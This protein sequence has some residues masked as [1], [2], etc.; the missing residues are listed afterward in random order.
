VRLHLDWLDVAAFAVEVQAARRL[1][2]LHLDRL[3]LAAFA[4][5]LRA[6]RRLVRLHLDWLGFGASVR[7]LS[8][9]SSFWAFLDLPWSSKELGAR[10]ANKMVLKRDQMRNGS[11]FGRARTRRDQEQQAEREPRARSSSTMGFQGGTQESVR[12]FNE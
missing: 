12:S 8:A 7:H 11:D 4:V 5:D 6:A 10:S 3:A 1:L 9:F 2:R